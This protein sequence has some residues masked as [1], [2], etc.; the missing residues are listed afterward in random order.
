MRQTIGF[1]SAVA[2][3]A[4]LAA[5]GGGG[6]STG[7][8]L[9]VSGTYRIN[10]VSPSVGTFTATATL[11]QSGSQVTGDYRNSAGGTFRLDGSVSGTHVTGQLIGTNN[12]AVCSA[13]GDFFPDGRAGHGSFNCQAG[14]R[15]VDSGTFTITRTG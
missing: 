1:V 13:E 4:T 12:P 15:T 11:Q 14:G 3:L 8:T 5:C 7:P 6:G 10:G 2:L 9:D